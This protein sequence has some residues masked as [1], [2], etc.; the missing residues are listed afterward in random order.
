VI[1]FLQ[2]DAL[3]CKARQGGLVQDA[4]VLVDAA[5]IQEDGK[6]TILGVTVAIGE[7][8]LNWRS[9][10]EELLQR[11]LTG[12]RMISSDDHAGLRAAQKAVFGGVPWQRC[13]F[14]MQQNAA[15]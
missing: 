5:G 6:R 3:W 1:P 2:L 10:M 14:H 7:H 13:Q 8:E 4:A 9:F 11:G 15:A 12:V